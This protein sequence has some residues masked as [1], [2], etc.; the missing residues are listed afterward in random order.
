MSNKDNEIEKL[1]AAGIIGAALGALLSKNKTQGVAIGAIVGAALSAS[2]QAYEN[3]T[4]ADVP[5]MVEEDGVLYKIHP[6]G[7]KTKVKK[8]RKPDSDLPKKFTI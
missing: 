5:V 3:A 1:V 6:G 8:L 7:K 4:K 2:S